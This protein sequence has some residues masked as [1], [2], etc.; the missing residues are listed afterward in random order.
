MSVL[1][2]G[3]E[4]PHDCYECYFSYTFQGSRHCSLL[5]D[6]CVAIYLHKRAEDCPL[7]EIP[8]GRV[9]VIISPE[10]EGVTE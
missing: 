10:E 6:G 8:N 2:K 1:I 4:V 3:M 9:N 7:V 5:H